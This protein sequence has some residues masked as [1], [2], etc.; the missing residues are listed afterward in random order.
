[1]ETKMIDI[2]SLHLVEQQNESA[3]QQDKSMQHYIKSCDE[4][5]SRAERKCTP[6]IGDT[7]N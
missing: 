2:V 3:H 4:F 6:T 5:A 1:M 7:K